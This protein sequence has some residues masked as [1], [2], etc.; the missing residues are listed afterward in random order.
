MLFLSARFQL[1]RVG[2]L[3]RKSSTWALGSVIV[4]AWQNSAYLAASTL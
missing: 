3:L 1:I 2:S 4:L